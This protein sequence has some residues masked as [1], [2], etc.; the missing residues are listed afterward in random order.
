[1][2]AI[3]SKVCLAEGFEKESMGLWSPAFLP[4]HYEHG[5]D[6][7]VCAPDGSTS[8]LYLKGGNDSN[9][10]M[11]LRLPAPA[12]GADDD[13]GGGP[14]EPPRPLP[15]DAESEDPSAFDGAFKPQSVAFYVRTDHGRADAGHFI[16][17][18]SNEVNKRVAQFQFTKDGKMGLLGTQGVT[19]GATPYVAHKWY[20]VELRFD[21]EKRE[22]RSSAAAA[23]RN[24][25]RKKSA[26]NSAQ[27]S[28]A[29]PPPPPLLQVAFFVDSVLQKRHIP[30]R[31]DTSSFIGACALGNRDKCTTWF[32]S[33]T[34]VQE[35]TLFRRDFFASG[36]E[37]RAWVGPLREETSRDG[38]YLRA[39]AGSGHVSTTAH[40][41]PR[42]RHEG[43]QRVAINGAALR[44]F[45]SL[46]ADASGSDVTFL[47]EG[48]ELHAHRCVLMV[49]RATRL[50]PHHPAFHRTSNP[51]STPPLA[52]GAVGGLPRDV[53]VEHA[54]GLEGGR[55]PGARPRSDP[56][57]L[58]VHAALPLRCDS[59]RASHPRPT[60]HL[61]SPPR[62]SS[63][64]RLRR[65]RAR[66][67]L[68][69]AARAG[70]PLLQNE[71]KLLCAHAGADDLGGDRLPH[72][73]GGGPMGRS[74]LAA[75]RAVHRV[76][77]ATPRPRRAI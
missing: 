22:V 65:H 3:T 66:G 23:A 4:G 73:A 8:S 72:R 10:G 24:S 9:F 25:D 63:L 21:W 36:G 31:R 49:R 6:T 59:G 50:P 47:V 56:R 68:R 71:L 61:F 51:A 67:P 33:I 13:G 7:E 5:F 29:R 35:V 43:A 14:A 32:D 45:A 52:A 28:E 55:P 42:G 17:G 62:C 76:R 41:W 58:P 46:L 34:F 19:H 75:A 39:E 18:E 26:Q 64:C 16:L 69:R 77:D 60:R 70:L 2:S 27:C 15:E 20:H 74:R 40:H 11:T 53:L 37:V 54:R 30:F 57:R 44:D 38:F 12:A 1:M 48:R